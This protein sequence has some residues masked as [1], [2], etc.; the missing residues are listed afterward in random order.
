MSEK[1]YM[2]RD[3]QQ[4]QKEDVLTHLSAAGICSAKNGGNGWGIHFTDFQINVL[5]E[6]V[7]E[8]VS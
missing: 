5:R 2:T 3:F 6:L 4:R 7:K 8:V 1:M